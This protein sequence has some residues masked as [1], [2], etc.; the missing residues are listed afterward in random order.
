MKAWFA[1]GHNQLP[2][3]FDFQ[4]WLQG[5][6]VHVKRMKGELDYTKPFVNMEKL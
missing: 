4:K 1:I 6:D 3:I 2:V 5:L